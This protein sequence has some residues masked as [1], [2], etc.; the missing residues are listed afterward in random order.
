VNGDKP[1]ALGSAAAHDGEYDVIAQS[2]KEQ[3]TIGPA[4][5]RPDQLLARRAAA[6]SDGASQGLWLGYTLLLATVPFV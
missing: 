5:A 4:G 1:G 6:F 3:L 2:N